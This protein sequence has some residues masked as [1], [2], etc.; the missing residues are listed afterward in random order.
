MGETVSGPLVSHS[1][2]LAR[3]PFCVV[4][5]KADLLP[6]DW[7]PPTVDAPEAWGQY[8]ISAVSHQGLDLLLEALWTR[9]AVR[10]SQEEVAGF[11][12]P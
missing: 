1:A 8:L 5:T 2:E 9:A 11:W 12:E 6:P 10:E 7:P 4:F 3:K